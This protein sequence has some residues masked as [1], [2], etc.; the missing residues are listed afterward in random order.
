MYNTENKILSTTQKST[1][2][3]ICEN[4]IISVSNLPQPLPSSSKPFTS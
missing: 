1:T 2:T 4:L 3:K